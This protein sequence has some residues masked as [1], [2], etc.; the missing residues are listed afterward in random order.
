MRVA[1]VFAMPNLIELVKGALEA[2]DVPEEGKKGKKTKKGK[3]VDAGK[4]T[5]QD[6][7]NLLIKELIDG[8]KE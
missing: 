5:Q 2:A 7:A 8:L 6:Q 3:A 4:N 1:R